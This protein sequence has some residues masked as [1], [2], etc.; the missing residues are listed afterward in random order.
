MHM[1]VSGLRYEHSFRLTAVMRSAGS[2]QAI[3]GKI[4]WEQPTP[5]LQPLQGCCAF[6][7]K[8]PFCSRAPSAS[9]LLSLSLPQLLAWPEDELGQGTGPEGKKKR[10]KNCYTL[11]Y[12]CL[13]FFTF[14]KIILL[15]TSTSSFDNIVGFLT[16][17][18]KRKCLDS[19]SR[20]VYTKSRVHTI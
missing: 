20:N 7:S 6:S 16:N 14:H 15:F 19:W 11:Y 9:M 4:P 5:L 10:K 12:S 13:L 17:E 1:H 2:N 3:C 8:P 18:H